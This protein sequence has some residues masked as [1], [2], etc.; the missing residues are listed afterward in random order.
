MSLTVP[1][2]E[3]DP[4]FQ[5]N[6]DENNEDVLQYAM[7]DGAME[8]ELPVAAGSADQANLHSLQRVAAVFERKWARRAIP[9][10]VEIAESLN[11]SR[12]TAEVAI[13]ACAEMALRG[14]RRLLECVVNYVSCLAE[15]KALEQIAITEHVLYDE[16]PQWCT[17]RH[18]SSI[19]ELGDKVTERAALFVIEASY[20]LLLRQLVEDDEMASAHPRGEYLLLQVPLSASLRVGASNAAEGV[21]AVMKS[22]LPVLDTSGFAGSYR[23]AECDEHAGNMRAEAMLCQQHPE[24]VCSTIICNAHKI[25]ASAMFS[26]SLDPIPEL[27]HGLIHMALWLQSG[28]SYTNFKKVFIA[29]LQKRPVKVYL[30]ACSA[31]ASAHRE[32]CVKAFGPEPRTEP[33]RAV[34]V[35]VLSE[36]I[37]N[38]SW[39][40]H[41]IEHH[42]SPSCCRSLQ[43]THQKLEFFTKKILRMMRP[44]VFQKNNWRDWHRG[45]KFFGLLQ[46]MHG[47][48]QSA[49]VSANASGA[50][51]EEVMG[52][53]YLPADGRGHQQAAQDPTGQDAAQQREQRQH[54]LRES[55]KFLASPDVA[56]Q[57]HRYVQILVQALRPERELMRE[58]LFLTSGEREVEV[59]GDFQAN[60][61]NVIAL[62]SQKHVHGMMQLALVNANTPDVWPLG[63]GDSEK[64]RS[65]MFRL[66]WRSPATV[67]QLVT[68][69]TRNY[70]YRLFSLLDPQASRHEL[71]AEILASRPCLH[72]DLTKSILREFHTPELLAGQRC[73]QL[74]AALGM[75]VVG[76]TFGTERLHSRNKRRVSG[77]TQTN[78]K[79]VHSIAATHAAWTGRSWMQPEHVVPKGKGGRPK[80]KQEDKEADADNDGVLSKEAKRRRKHGGGGPWRAYVHYM[81]VIEKQ[82]RDFKVLKENY[83]NMSVDE[84][85]WFRHLGLQGYELLS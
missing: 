5:S 81:V 41:A 78:V 31:Q 33:R 25:H 23:I 54:H 61:F 46:G 9:P 52:A 14:Q 21:V 43:E 82:P 39:Q 40:S 68:V 6:Q 80:R 2:I 63:I 11:M 69:R 59:Q 83:R 24:R 60:S 65:D 73:L 47:L 13:N 85:A 27:L 26:F 4:C 35:R 77:V 66:M 57:W 38:G 72:D 79:E 3:Q 67:Y 50:S 49:F 34:W 58:V 84:K 62:H 22:A 17:V 8:P 51:A 19:E 74:L 29:E 48:L 16:T 7:G 12:S 18:R 45:L 75:N 15:A 64:Y 30:H 56:A 20:T 10:L 71:A 53:S 42:C 44:C 76:A 32:R 37:M 28:A 36:K 70:P 1:T 55:L